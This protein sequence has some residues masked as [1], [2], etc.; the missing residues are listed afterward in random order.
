MVRASESPTLR[1]MKASIYST[2]DTQSYQVW[3]LM[4]LPCSLAIARDDLVRSDD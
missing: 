1:Q 3:I 2:D 4:A